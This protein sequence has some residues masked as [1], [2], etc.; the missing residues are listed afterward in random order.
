[1][2]LKIDAVAAGLRLDKAVAD[3]TELSRGLANEQIKNGQILVNGEAKKAKYAVKEGDVISYEV[4]EP[5]V[6]EYVA[7]D[8]PLEIVYQDEDVAVVNKPQGMV[9]HPSAGHTSGTLVNALMY[10][11]KDLS[12]INGVLRP[13]IVH[14][15]DKDTSGLLMIAKNDQAH[16]ALADELKDKKSLRKYWAIVHGNLP[17]D[18]GV[19]EAPIGRSEKDRKKQAVTAKG[20]PALT[21]FQVLERFGDYTLVELQLETG[22]THQIRVHMAYI[23]HPVAGDEVYGPRKTLKGHGQFL[24]ARTLGFTHPRTGEVLEFTAEAPAIFLETLEKLRK[25]HD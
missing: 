25:A 7:E 4:P 5:E 11:I 16:L 13:G 3:L 20:K 12:G 15:I 10:H 21:R 14:R 23:G 22:R 2:E 9:V 6:V 18:R 1:M 17:N 8:L 19:I 24:H